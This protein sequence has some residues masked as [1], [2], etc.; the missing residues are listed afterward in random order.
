MKQIT[1]RF[2]I[3]L[4]TFSIGIFVAWIW[5]FTGNSNI[6]EISNISI[7]EHQATVIACPGYLPNQELNENEDYA[8]YSEI[9]SGKRYNS[10]LIVINDFTS[11]G[12][13]ADAKNLNYEIPS[14][15]QD[16]IND[17]QA[18]KI[19]S[20]KLEN[21]FTVSGKVVFLSE[22]EVTQLFN[23]GLDG[24]NKFNK[25]YPGANGIITLSRVG[26]N[27]EKTQALVYVGISCGGLCGGGSFMFL[28]KRNGKWSIRGNRNLW[29]S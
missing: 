29:V 26:F 9:L 22:E 23:I 16:T 17:Y 21:N 11:Q 3:A 10:D 27:K 12:L 25:K 20:R 13:I 18:K 19:E 7:K 5:L 2:S 28:E 15:T 14:L 24:W 4:L 8:V 1:F 6:V